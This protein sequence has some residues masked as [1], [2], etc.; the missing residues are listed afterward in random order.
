MASTNVR[1]ERSSRGNKSPAAGGNRVRTS[2]TQGSRSLPSSLT[3]L[4]P[5]GALVCVI[6]SILI[7]SH[8]AFFPTLAK[9]MPRR[10]QI[11]HNEPKA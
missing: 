3:D 7:V 5:P 1:A 11:D 9:T 6:L 2:S 10:K 8:S 4:P